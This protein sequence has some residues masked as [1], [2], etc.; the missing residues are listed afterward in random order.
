MSGGGPGLVQE[1]FTLYNFS[2]MRCSLS[3]A[4]P[5][6]RRCQDQEPTLPTIQP[7]SPNKGALSSLHTSTADRPAFSPPPVVYTHA[8]ATASSGSSTTESVSELTS[9]SS[10]DSL[11]AAQTR[12]AGTTPQKLARNNRRPQASKPKARWSRGGAS[13]DDTGP[14][15]KPPTSQPLDTT[16]PQ[17]TYPHR[18]PH[19]ATNNPA[20]IQGRLMATTFGSPSGDSR[21]GVAS[22]RPKG[23]G[24]DLLS[25]SSWHALM[26]HRRSEEHFLPQCHNLRTLSVREQ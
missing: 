11:P 13:S 7:A 25:I 15:R 4:L 16:P 9:Q 18:Q 19:L 17:R 21:R 24:M 6:T 10:R 26:G 20:V 22:P 12:S 3:N 5:E 8:N 14:D 1:P 2:S 23:R